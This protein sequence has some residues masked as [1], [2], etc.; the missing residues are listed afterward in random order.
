MSNNL[1]T[2]KRIG[3]GIRLTETATAEIV[4]TLPEGFD[5]TAR[6]A[7]S[8]AV[9]AWACGSEEVPPQKIGPK[10]NQ[11]ATDFGRGVDALVKSVKRALSGDTDKPIVLRA[12]L[13]GEGGGS[14]V[15]PTDS[16]LYA[17]L[18]AMIRDGGEES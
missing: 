1:N 5:H 13:S 10:G 9:I 16:P 6:G 12:T 18:V 11:R 7:V 4:A 15:I 2:V 14:T 17:A 3:S 8:G